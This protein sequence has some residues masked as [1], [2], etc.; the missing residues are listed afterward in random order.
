[1]DTQAED[2]IRNLVASVPELQKLDY[3]YSSE[4]PKA[5]L[6]AVGIVRAL[7]R[8]TLSPIHFDKR[9]NEVNRDS[10]KFFDHKD[11]F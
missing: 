10:G 4:E 1:M 11:Q 8:E 2:E 9:L 3:L 5:K 7:N 6:T